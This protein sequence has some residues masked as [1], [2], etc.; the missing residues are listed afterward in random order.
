[1]NNIIDFEYSKRRLVSEK[2]IENLMKNKRLKKALCDVYNSKSINKYMLLLATL[3]YENHKILKEQMHRTGFLVGFNPE[4]IM[5]ISQ[6]VELILKNIRREYI[7]VEGK[8][9][10]FIDCIKSITGKD[11]YRNNDAFTDLKELLLNGNR[12]IIFK[13]F[14]NTK[15]Q[16]KKEKNYLI[17]SIIKIFDNIYPSNIYPLSD[18]IFIDYA[19]FLQFCW[20]NIG[21][22]LKVMP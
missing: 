4:H 1:M 21:S 6:E 17:R 13:E 3:F 12:V 8:G 22:Y 5:S 15:M 7:F 20:Y 2:I 16:S 19:D 14:S 18:L 9:K 11:Y 10:S